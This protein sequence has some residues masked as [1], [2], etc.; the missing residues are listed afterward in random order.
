M[1]TCVGDADRILAR[2]LT[3]FLSLDSG[4]LISHVFR[5]GEGAKRGL[6]WVS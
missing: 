3:P 1:V 2:A 5:E 4:P 6:V